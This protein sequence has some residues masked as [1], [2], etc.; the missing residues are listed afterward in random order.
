MTKETPATV[1][2]E[3][4]NDAIDDNARKFILESLP[5][6]FLDAMGAS[7]FDLTSDWI[8]LGVEEIK[9]ARKKFDDGRVETLKITK[10]TDE[11]G[12]R[13]SIKL[14]IDDEKEYDKGLKS[15]LRR[16]VKRRYGFKYTQNGHEYDVKYDVFEGGLLH[17][18]EVEG[19]QEERDGFDYMDFMVPLFEVTKDPRYTG[20]EV[21]SVLHDLRGRG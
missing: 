1:T 9:L 8:Q 17:M 12:N 7:A 10:V 15:S 6:E 3:H 20:S 5:E 13:T 11:N 21:V 4:A 19:T 14:P 2:P 16:V 18:I